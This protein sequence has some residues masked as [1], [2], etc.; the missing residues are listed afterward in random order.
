[1]YNKSELF[2]NKM[3]GLPLYYL[4]T[5]FWGK[6]NKRNSDCELKITNFRNSPL[7][8]H[9]D[10][11]FIKFLRCLILTLFATSRYFTQE[12]QKLYRVHSIILSFISNYNNLSRENLTMRL[13]YLHC[14]LQRRTEKM[15]KTVTFLASNIS[16]IF[17]YFIMFFLQSVQF[18]IIVRIF[19]FRNKGQVR[20]S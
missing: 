18:A 8:S 16:L 4:R 10:I 7:G 9:C 17:S 11:P 3:Y 13:N 5:K 1:M 14:L 15:S 12:L 2:C 6:Q 19:P 20:C